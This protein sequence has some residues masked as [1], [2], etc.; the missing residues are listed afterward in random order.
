MSGPKAPACLVTQ[1]VGEVERAGKPPDFIQPVSQP[2]LTTR[3]IPT[4][5]VLGAEPGEL[6]PPFARRFVSGVFCSIAA[7]KADLPH[8]GSEN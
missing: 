7:E 6:L 4:P 1:A 5:T 3:L 8:M 2:S